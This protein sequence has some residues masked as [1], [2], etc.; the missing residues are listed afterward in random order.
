MANAHNLGLSDSRL[1]CLMIGRCLRLRPGG[2][3][4]LPCPC[5]RRELEGEGLIDASVEMGAARDL[6]SRTAYWEGWQVKVQEAKGGCRL[7]PSTQPARL[8]SVD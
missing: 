7:T 6:L 1:P 3:S 8:R 2:N 4:Q 5:P